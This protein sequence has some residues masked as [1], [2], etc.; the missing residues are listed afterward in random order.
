M[1]NLVFNHHDMLLK[2]LAVPHEHVPELPFRDLHP[3]TVIAGDRALSED[4]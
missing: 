3:R 4:L 2:C 1:A